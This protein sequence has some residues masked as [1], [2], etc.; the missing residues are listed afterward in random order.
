RHPARV[1][2]ADIPVA[3]CPEGAV[4]GLEEGTDVV[5]AQAFARGEDADPAVGD[6]VQAAA[7]GTD[8][9]AVVAGSQDGVDLVVGEAVARR[10]AREGNVLEPGET[11]L[12]CDRQAARLG[13]VVSVGVSVGSPPT[14][15][16]RA[17]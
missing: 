2:A 5:A 7:I 12:R 16:D 17:V 10:V 14:V 3:P 6:L 8:P 1:D 4:P 13:V 9:D 11:P 15:V